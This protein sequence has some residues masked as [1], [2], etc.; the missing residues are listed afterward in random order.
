MEN[1]NDSITIKLPKLKG[2]NTSNLRENPWIMSTFVLIVLAI[3]LLFTSSGGITGNVISEKE[4]GEKVLLLAQ[5]EDVNAELVSIQQ[6]NGFYEAIISINGEEFPLYIT[7]DGTSLISGIYPLDVILGEISGQDVPL[8]EN[9]VEGSTFL[10]TNDEILRDG[11]GKPYVILVSTTWCP[12]CTWIKDTFDGLANGEYADLINLQHWELDTFD[13]TLTSEIE[14]EVPLY[15]MEMY[16]KYNPSG[17]IPT[18]I[19]GGKYSR[20]GN[21]YEAEDDLDAE[22]ADFELIISKLLE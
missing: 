16:E 17:T 21:G 8:N 22:L 19:F 7:L 4:A 15:V 1:S 20:T 2:I 13:N 14:T 11:E 12:H 3:V 10:D 6:T 18:F 9:P 5:T